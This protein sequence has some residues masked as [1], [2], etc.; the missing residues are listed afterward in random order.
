LH[1]QPGDG[2]NRRQ[3]NGT[4]EMFHS[5]PPALTHYRVF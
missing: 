5:F 1:E 4:I 3:Q 2:R